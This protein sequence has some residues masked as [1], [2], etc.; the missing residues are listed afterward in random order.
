MRDET[1]KNQNSRIHWHKKQRSAQHITHCIAL[2]LRF[3]SVG[4]FFFVLFVTCMFYS[5]W[6][7]NHHVLIEFEQPD[8]DMYLCVYLMRVSRNNTPE[9]DCFKKQSAFYSS[10]TQVGCCFLFI[11]FFLLL[12]LCQKIAIEKKAYRR[13]K[14]TTTSSTTKL[15][16]S[17]R[18]V[19]FNDLIYIV[20]K[21]WN[22]CAR[23]WKGNGSL[24]LC[25][26]IKW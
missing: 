9:R 22:C 8:H 3:S 14:T 23:M 26:V 18:W 12:Y 25:M 24:A 19:L 21:Q 7:N 20:S 6:T 1:I 11:L 4:Y 13:K 2:R 5:Q 17:F 16:V 10:R 15:K